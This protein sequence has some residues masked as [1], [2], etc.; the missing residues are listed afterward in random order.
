GFVLLALYLFAIWVFTGNVMERFDAIADNS[1]LNRCSYDQQSLRILLKRI[2]IGFFELSIFQSLATAFIFVFAILFQRN[3]LRI[4]RL[5]DSFSFFTVS[6]IILFL[7]SSFMT[8]SPSSY[9]PMCLDPRHYLFLV[10]VASIPASRIIG[11]FIESKKYALQIIIAL[12]CISIISFFLQGQTFILLY[13]PLLVLFTIYLI[14]GKSKLYQY[15][16]IILFASILLLL[17][18]DMCRYAQKVKYRT[19]KEIAIEQVLENKSD[20]IIVTDEIQKRLL[21][22]YSSF[23]EENDSRFLNFEEFETDPT[24]EGKKLLL[25]NWYTRY[26][27]GMEQNDLPYFARNISS[28]NEPIFESKDPD[29][30]IYELNTFLL[31]AHS[32]ALLLSTFNDFEQLTPYW[33]QNDR[34]ISGKIKYEGANSNL[35]AEFSATFD[36]PLDSLHIKDATNL[37]IQCSLFCYAEDNTGA[38][39]IVSVED[40]SGTYI[41][42]ALEVDKYLKAY[43]NWWP[44]TFDVVIPLQN[45]QPESRLKVYVWRGDEPDVYIDNFGVTIY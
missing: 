45:L 25:L 31:P 20:Y 39:I 16:F 12:L 1:Y 33:N 22:Y 32:K 23:D 28:V 30:S 34:D 29:I 44:L 26:L 10:P 8:I 13:L 18:L 11:D 27:S 9:A 43:S 14:A 5:D 7:S 38:R 36:Y 42:K 6:A 37:Q 40:S 15:L 41:W 2:F 4:F 24:V 3:G 17:P 21:V 19:Q 35:V